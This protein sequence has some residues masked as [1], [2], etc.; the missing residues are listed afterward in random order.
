MDLISSI[1]GITAASAGGIF[2]VLMIIFAIVA[3]LIGLGIFI[4]WIITLID[5]IKRDDKDFAVGGTN[6]KIIWLLLLILVNN[7]VPIIYYFVIMY[8]KEDKKPS[9]TSN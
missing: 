9:K 5:C 7:I 4:L 1:A 6:A 8:K 3:S 2:V